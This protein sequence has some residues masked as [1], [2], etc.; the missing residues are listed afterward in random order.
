MCEAAGWSAGSAGSL[1]TLHRKLCSISCAACAA[2]WAARPDGGANGTLPDD[3]SR[4]EFA[5]SIGEF[6]P[7]A[8][9][10]SPR[11]PNSCLTE[12]V[13]SVPRLTPPNAHVSSGG[14]DDTSEH[15]AVRSISVRLQI[16][17]ARIVTSLYP[18]LQAAPRL[19]RGRR[20]TRMATVGDREPTR[21]HLGRQALVLVLVKQAAQL[22]AVRLE[23]RRHARL[24]RRRVGRAHAHRPAPRDRDVD[25]SR[26]EPGQAPPARDQRRRHAGRAEDGG[27]RAPARVGGVVRLVRARPSV[28]GRRVGLEPWAWGPWRRDGCREGGRG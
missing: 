26:H 6:G 23:D 17:T 14:S 25:G 24:G 28:S 8:R 12:P 2:H 4:A 11:Q 27:R 1:V 9:A 15:A 7:R 18:L 16:T 5:R 21:G 13:C 19:R 3:G 10:L 20:F 22:G